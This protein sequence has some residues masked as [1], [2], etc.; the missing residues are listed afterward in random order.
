MSAISQLLGSVSKRLTLPGGLAIRLMQLREN[1]R[2]AAL[3]IGAPLLVVAGLGGWL[4]WRS[5][6][7][8]KPPAAKAHP[9]VVAA[10]APKPE[11]KAEHL[12]QASAQSA[13]QPASEAAPEA[14]HKEESADKGG[15]H[16][17]QQLV[18]GVHSEPASAPGLPESHSAAPVARA[19]KGAHKAARHH[20]SARPVVPAEAGSSEQAESAGAAAGKLDKRA[21]QG[22]VQQQADNEFRKA[23]AA[24]QQGHINDA[25]AGFETALQIDPGHEA[26]RQALVALLLENKRNEDAERVLKEGLDRNLKNTQFAMVL[27]RLQLERDSPWSALLTLQKT[28]PYASQQADYQAFVAAMLQ[29]VGR[30]R[31]AVARY[32]KALQLKPDSAVWL[33][34]QG[35]SWQ[36]LQ[37]KEEARDAFKR[38]M[39]MHTL[40]EDL[41]AFI[42]QRMKEL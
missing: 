5:M 31:E 14:A 41:Q 13:V 24:M 35:I 34:G 6:H 42:M 39:D 1:K 23:V 25:L 30:H 9:A 4:G 27:A 36:A 12:P 22:S 29:R 8:A 11:A 28:L 38:A 2:R 37:R 18:P 15:E 26:A 19:E 20:R 3:L 40:N 7:P 17:P 32:Q 10:A 33:M 21:K 16:K